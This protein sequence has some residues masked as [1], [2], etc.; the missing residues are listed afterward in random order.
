MN[1]KNSFFFM[2]VTEGS[3]LYRNVEFLIVRLLDHEKEMFTFF[4]KQ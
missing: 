3:M 4:R 2:I 1:L